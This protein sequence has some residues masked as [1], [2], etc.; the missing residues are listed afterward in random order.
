M[1]TQAPRVTISQRT[2]RTLGATGARGSGDSGSSGGGHPAGSSGDDEEEVERARARRHGGGGSSGSQVPSLESIDDP[3]VP[4]GK[5]GAWVRDPSSLP[6]AYKQSVDSGSGKHGG[7]SGVESSDGSD[8]EEW[9][10]PGRPKASK[11][12]KRPLSQR[13]RLQP[14]H[15][16][17]LPTSLPSVT[18]PHL[19]ELGPEAQRH[20]IREAFRE[21]YRSAIYFVAFGACIV[22]ALLAW[23]SGGKFKKSSP[24]CFQ[25]SFPTAEGIMQNVP[26][27]LKGVRVGSVKA[28]AVN[29]HE[30]VATVEIHNAATR[31][32]APSLGTRYDYNR[33]GMMAPEPWVDITPPDSILPHNLD[34][35]GRPRGGREAAQA[36]FIPTTTYGSGAGATAGK[37][38]RS[39]AAASSPADDVARTSDGSAGS[40]GSAKRGTGA[41]VGD[42]RAAAASS[43]SKAAAAEGEDEMPDDP[44]LAAKLATCAGPKAGK[45]C[46]EHGLLVCENDKVAGSLG[47]SVDDM[48]RMMVVANR[49]PGRIQDQ[50]WFK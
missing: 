29:L 25:I 2:V 22:A 30:V 34:P 39:D 15:F 41:A 6:A 31:I 5:L 48:T 38:L 47:G 4:P 11:G 16:P 50:P 17:K 28:V 35:K 3:G 46:H 7:G 32:P 26:V 27:R 13:P 36:A 24:Y 8:G 40:S 43:T 21:V 42:A 37:A 44:L 49:G 45:A 12:G 9:G 14:P 23:A 10:E 19:E 1:H 18:M 20:S 33:T